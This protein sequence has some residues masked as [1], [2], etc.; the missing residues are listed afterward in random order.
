MAGHFAREHDAQRHE[1]VLADD[2]DGAGF[3]GELPV[4][5]F[6]VAGEDD[7]PRRGMF[8]AQG[9]RGLEAVEAGHVYIHGDPVGLE[10]AHALQGF[11]ARGA[12]AERDAGQIQK[13][14]DHLPRGV[15]VINNHQSHIGI[16]RLTNLAEKR[17]ERNAG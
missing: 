12:L 8:G 3:A 16:F 2:G 7:D 14:A 15:V 11:L 1:I 10:L 4:M 17:A 13:P 9:G 5:A 6:M